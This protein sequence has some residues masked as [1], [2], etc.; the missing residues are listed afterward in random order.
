MNG[1]GAAHE[2]D[3]LACLIKLG[4]RDLRVR[5]YDTQVVRSDMG[6]EWYRNYGRE[7]DTSF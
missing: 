5:P 3:V 4:R 2:M 1:H 6:G 7:D